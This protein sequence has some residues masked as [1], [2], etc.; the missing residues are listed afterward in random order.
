MG[1]LTEL[2]KVFER[3]KW[4]NHLERN[5]QGQQAELIREKSIVDI[6]YSI[7]F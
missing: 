4:L 7:V 6:P 2:E 1:R 5:I 3:E